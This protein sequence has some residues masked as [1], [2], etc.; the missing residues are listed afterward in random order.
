MI[1]RYTLAALLG[2]L[3][4]LGIMRLTDRLAH[5]TEVALDSQAD[6][7]ECKQEMTPM[8]GAVCGRCRENHKRAVGRKS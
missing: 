5:I 4:A 7:T 2:V 6:T 8:L 1:K 3:L